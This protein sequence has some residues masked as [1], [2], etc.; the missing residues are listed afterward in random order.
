MRETRG[1]S[2]FTEKPLRA[3]SRSDVLAQD[4]DR[5]LAAMLPLFGKMDDR[6]SSLAEDALYV[7]AIFKGLKSRGLFS[8]Y[9]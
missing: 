3:D 4:F 8:W 6:H 5:D 1:D 9:A 2:D 7:I